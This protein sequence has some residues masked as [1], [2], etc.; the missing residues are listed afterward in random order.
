MKEALSSSE[1]SVLR[2]ATGRNIP[3]DAILQLVSM[4]FLSL[5]GAG[6]SDRSK[7]GNVPNFV[8][9]SDGRTDF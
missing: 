1:K 4:F 9:K 5:N 7:T 2:R 8:T 6:L 3:E